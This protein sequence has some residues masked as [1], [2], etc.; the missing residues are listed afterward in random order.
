MKRFLLGAPLLFSVMSCADLGL[1]ADPSVGLPSV[2]EREAA[3]KLADVADAY[4]NLT[5]EA[6]THE[7]EWVDAYYGPPEKLAAAKA[8]PRSLAELRTAAHALIG[9]LDGGIMAGLRDP[10]EKRRAVALRGMLVAADTRLQM[11]Q[12]RKFSFSHFCPGHG[13]VIRVAPD[14]DAMRTTARCPCPCT[15]CQHCTNDGCLT[16]CRYENRK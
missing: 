7:A 4:I 16:P 1:V 12:G 13:V 14:I 8:N 11:L 6:G 5:L 15:M 9:Q 10:F 3:V 2:N